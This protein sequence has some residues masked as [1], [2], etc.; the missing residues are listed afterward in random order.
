HR[1]PSP[2]QRH[3][4]DLLPLP[5]TDPGQLRYLRQERTAR[6]ALVRL[7]FTDGEYSGMRGYLQETH[8]DEFYVAPVLTPSAPLPP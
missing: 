7:F 3:T 5:G 2:I 6:M 1:Q 4:P 8:C